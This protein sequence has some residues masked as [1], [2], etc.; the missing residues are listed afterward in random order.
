MKKKLTL[1]SLN[2]LAAVVG[3]VGASLLFSCK[4]DTPAEVNVGSFRVFNVSPTLN[5]YD[6]YINS[7]KF[8]TA[9]LPFGGGVKY[10]T[11]AA[12]KYDV[13]FT[14]AGETAAVYEA[15]D[16]NIDK[17]IGYSLFLT[18]NGTT[19][20][21]LYIVDDYVNPV[22]TK[23]YI[24]FVNLSPDAQGLELTMNDT[25]IV[26]NKAYKTYSDFTPVN[27]GD[28]VFAI[29]DANSTKTTLAST[30]LAGGFFY[31]IISRGKVTPASDLERNFSGQIIANQ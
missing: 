11:L 2:N 22:M 31:T 29:K 9:A 19:L 27:P 30:K 24:R 21:Q 20:D 26:A 25:S 7:Q 8:N 6:V 12:G 3:I 23:S 10:T 18:G 28:K 1:L 5:T 13:K 16:L 15:K 14:T 4:T 17:N